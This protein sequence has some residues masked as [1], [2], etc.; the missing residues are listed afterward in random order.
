MWGMKEKS[1]SRMRFMKILL[2]VSE[3]RARAN[4]PGLRTEWGERSKEGVSAWRDVS[5]T[6][7]VANS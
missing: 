1:N 6:I 4:G 2:V 7:A 3:E 5:S